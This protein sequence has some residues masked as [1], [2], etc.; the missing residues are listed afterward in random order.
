MLRVITMT[1]YKRPHSTRE[2]LDALAACD[3][4]ADWIVLPNVEPGNEEVINAFRN[5]D[6]CDSHLIVNEH[7]LG[8]NENTHA[9][10]F[11]AYELRA[12]RIVHIEDDTVPSPDALRFFDWAIE[13]VL[14]RQEHDRILLASGYS[15][16]N[17]CPPVEMSHACDVRAIWWPWGWAVDRSRLGWLMRHWSFQESRYFT[18]HF[19][20]TYADTRR[21]V[22][23]CLSRFQNIGNPRH[24]TPWVAGRLENL[25]FR[26][27]PATGDVNRPCEN[28]Q[29]P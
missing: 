9:A 17:A 4:I 10:L 27:L 15:R 20:R 13:D 16:P 2:V 19:Q 21:E 28:A 25:S 18:R 6:A 22:F 1:A 26:L 24:H 3:G 7:Q 5:W 11:R 29:Q 14:S 8:L 12:D 23:P